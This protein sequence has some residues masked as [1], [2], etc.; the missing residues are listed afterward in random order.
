MAYVDH[1]SV[2]GAQYDIQDKEA[3]SFAQN[4]TLTD[5]QQEQARANIGA[6]SAADV[7]DLKTD[8]SYPRNTG[9]TNNSMVY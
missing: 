7:S 8:L 4:Q 2:D 9:N 1:I 3:V 5:A 6:G